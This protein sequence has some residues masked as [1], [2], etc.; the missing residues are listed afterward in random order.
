MAIRSNAFDAMDAL[1]ARDRQSRREADG[2]PLPVALRLVASPELAAEI[3]KSIADVKNFAAAVHD[4]TLLPPAATRF[5]GPVHRYGGS[6]LTDVRRRRPPLPA[7]DR[8][9]TTSSTT[10]IGWYRPHRNACRASQ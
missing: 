8:M 4:G 10:P 6:A 2:W 3:R 7:S 5:A 9:T 1:L